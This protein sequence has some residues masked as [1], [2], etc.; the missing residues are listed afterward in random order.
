[1]EQLNQ[2]YDEDLKF[3]TKPC[4][5]CPYTGNYTEGVTSPERLSSLLDKGYHL[6]HMT[7]NK[8]QDRIFHCAGHILAMNAI[9]K[10][11][12]NGQVCSAQKTLTHSD[13]DITLH[14]IYTG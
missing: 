9:G 3:R 1:M 8:R 7:G 4:G 6:C 12:D 11:S 2:Q 5:H 14:N 10:E 13:C